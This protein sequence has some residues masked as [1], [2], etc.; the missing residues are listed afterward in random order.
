[1]KNSDYMPRKEAD[2]YTWVTVFFT[3][4]ITNCSRFGIASALLSPL[5]SLR[6]D[7]FAK[8]LVAQTPSTR[9]K[10]TVLAKNNA[11]KALKDA[12]RVFIRE[13]LT[14]NHLVTDLDRDNLGLPIH[15]TDR[16][17]VPVPTTYPFFVIDSSM[18]RMLIIF[19]Y[20]TASRALAKPFGV[21]GAEIRWMV[22]DTPVINPEELIHSSFDTRSPLRL[23]FHGDDRGKTV[24]FCL[25]W[26]NTRGE[27]GPWSEIVSAVIP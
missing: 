26:E 7:F 22:S 25:R 11:L 10:T 24:W 20:A 23:E 13:Y 8:Y 18:I 9:T 14:N 21:H 15:K 5:L 16:K 12:L 1:M 4:L 2:F 19:F 17:P 3:Y 27:K 6:D